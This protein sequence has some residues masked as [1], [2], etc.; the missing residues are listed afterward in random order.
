M[1][2]PKPILWRNTLVKERKSRA[3]PTG[4]KCTPPQFR[5]APLISRLI[6]RRNRESDQ[7]TFLLAGFG[8][9]ASVS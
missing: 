1:R 4:T 8:L 3:L 5:D 6:R 9:S 7:D 2:S